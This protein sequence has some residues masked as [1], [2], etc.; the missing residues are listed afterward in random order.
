MTTP[1]TDSGSDPNPDG[2]EPASELR[3]DGVVAGYGDIEILH[4]VHLVAGAGKI[5]GLIGPNGSGKSTMLR[6]CS[7]SLSATDG[8]IVLCGKDV[9]EL[10]TREIAKRMAVLP[11]SPTT[12]P[13][14]TVRELVEQ[15]RYAHVGPLG[16]LRRKDFQRV[17]EAIGMVGLDEFVERDVD[18]LSG[19]ER[20]RA[21]LA[22]ALAQDTPVLALDEPTTYL[23][24]GHQ[25]EALE[26][27][28]RLNR[29][30]GVTVVVV[31]HDLNHAA[32]FCDHLVVLD[33]GRVVASGPP[34]DALTE[35]LLADHF[36]VRAS[37]SND[38]ET[39]HIIILPRGSA[40]RKEKDVNA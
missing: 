26:L 28:Q 13:Y 11:Q 7:R 16:M 4:D 22:L 32:Q 27:V 1:T 31:L 14:L 6:T 25:F 40:A 3:A 29:D 36:G 37:I 10:S 35:Q 9:A 23:D 21:W 12:P 8:S 2:A 39:G 5:T 20:Q 38:P 17:D 19:G 30:H 34:A 33:E 15:G 24:I 18:T